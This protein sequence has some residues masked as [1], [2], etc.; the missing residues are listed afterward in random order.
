MPV[1]SSLAAMIDARASTAQMELLAAAKQVAARL[2]APLYLVGGA[3]RDLLATGELRDLD[4]VVEGDAIELARQLADQIGGSFRAH[5]RFLT[6]EVATDE[7][8]ADLATARTE[9]YDQPATLPVVSTGELKD[10]LSRRDFT[11]NSM[12]YR[13]WPEEPALLVDPFSGQRDLDEG[14]LRALHERSFSDDPTRILRGVRLGSRLGM[15]MD[16]ETVRMATEAVASGAF[17]PL[18][19]SRLRQ[20]MILLLEEPEVEESLRRLE[21]VGFLRFLGLTA[22]LEAQ[23]WNA[24]KRLADQRSTLEPAADSRR[25]VRWWLAYLMGIALDSPASSRAEMAQRLDLNEDLAGALVEAG[26]HLEGV[27]SVLSGEDVEAH[28]VRRVL[29]TLT[30]EEIVLLGAVAEG[31]TKVW[32]ERWVDSLRHIQLAISGADLVDAGFLPGPEIG[33]AL[34]ATLDARADDLIEPSQELQFAIEELT[35]DDHSEVSE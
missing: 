35:G 25:P 1:E 26:E 19:A 10:D 4:L 7:I 14:W 17:E 13:L 3:V 22:P 29:E 23:H 24:V 33:R 32:F 15:R 34:E 30:L 28:T 21:E 8:R 12:A 20:E 6:S 31:T 9:I 2:R 18:S 11:V 5:N 16:P 27:V